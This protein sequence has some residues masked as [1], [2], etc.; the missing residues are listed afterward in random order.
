MDTE[1]RLRM[2]VANMILEVADEQQELTRSDFQGRADVVARD[3]I[4][5]VRD[6]KETE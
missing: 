3:I 4:R 5:L 1:M 2:D 6:A